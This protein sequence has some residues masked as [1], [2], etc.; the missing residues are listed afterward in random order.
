MKIKEFISKSD[1]RRIE[2]NLDDKYDPYNI[3]PILTGN[4]FFQ[5]VNDER[6]NPEITTDELYN[7]LK[8]PTEPPIKIIKQISKIDDKGEITITDPETNIN[9]PIIIKKQEGKETEMVAKTIMRKKDFKADNKISTE[10]TPE[11]LRKLLILRR[12]NEPK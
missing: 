11:Q 10:L 3:E 9:I 1:L 5:R 8:K 6:N 7:V 12:F 4:H 2:R